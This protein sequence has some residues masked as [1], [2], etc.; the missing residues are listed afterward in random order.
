MNKRF[1]I[2]KYKKN[3]REDIARICADTGF[4]GQPIDTIFEDRELFVDIS[5]S[6]YMDKEPQHILVALIDGVVV[7]YLIGWLNPELEKEIGWDV[8]RTGAKMAWRSFIG[9]YKKKRSIE[10]VA[11]IIFRGLK[12][13]PKHPKN[14]SRFHIN[15][16][17]NYRRYGIGK[18]LFSKYEAMLKKKSIKRYYGCTIDC[19]HSKGTIAFFKKTGFVLYDKVETSVFKK[20]LR[21]KAYRICIYKDLH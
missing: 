10:Y 8:F 9:K 20:E 1:T 17:K 19:K 15:I 18:E 13:T 7:G 5:A 14:A 21:S 4:V 2:R 12:E 6:F 16:D 11:W 3:D